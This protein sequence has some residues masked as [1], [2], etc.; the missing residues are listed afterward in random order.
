VKLIVPFAACAALASAALMTACGQ[1]QASLP[2]AQSR[3]QAL[4]SDSAEVT[5][6]KEAVRP[7]VNHDEANVQTFVTSSGVRARRFT[8]GFGTAVVAHRTP[9]G[10]VAMTCIDSEDGVDMAVNAPA[11]PQKGVR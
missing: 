5:R 1:G 7:Y 2:V 6:L 9:D 8:A 4:R 10:K 11:A 3:G